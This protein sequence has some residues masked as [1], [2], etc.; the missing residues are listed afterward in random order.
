LSSV[1]YYYD[2]DLIRQISDNF[3]RISQ[4][5]RQGL[6]SFYELQDVEHKPFMSIIQLSEQ[7]INHLSKVEEIVIPDA[8]ERKFPR[9]KEDIQKISQIQ[10]HAEMREFVLNISPN[11]PLYAWLVQSV[12]AL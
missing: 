9:W 12:L 6:Y 5:S 10:T 4:H 1:L 7:L 2:L 11:H 3:L 8:K